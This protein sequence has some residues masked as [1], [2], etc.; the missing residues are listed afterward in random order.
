VRKLVRV[1]DLWRVEGVA[2]V[3]MEGE[4]GVVGIGPGPWT[5]H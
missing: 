3:G 2:E 5:R 4:G 1:I